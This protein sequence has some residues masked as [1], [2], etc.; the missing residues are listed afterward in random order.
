[1]TRKL[2]CPVDFSE[3]S[4]RA[5]QSALELAQ[6]LGTTVQVF[7]IYE[8]G[9]V[10]P[11]PGFFLYAGNPRPLREIARDQAMRAMDE[12]AEAHADAT[13]GVN[14]SVLEGHPVDRILEESRTGEYEMIVMGTRGRTGLAHLLLGSVAEKVVRSSPIPVFTLKDASS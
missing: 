2:L 3:C 11:D 13:V 9:E 12:F 1:M 7:H 5:F 10:Q 4:E 6:S 14:Y 8:P